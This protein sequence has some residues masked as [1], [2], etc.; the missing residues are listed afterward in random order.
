MY[1]VECSTSVI[2]CVLTKYLY[3]YSF[4]STIKKVPFLNLYRHKSKK[5]TTFFIY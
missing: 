3:K 1:K 5:G 2:Y 4:N